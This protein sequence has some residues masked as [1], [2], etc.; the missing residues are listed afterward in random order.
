MKDCQKEEIVFKWIKERVTKKKRE[1]AELQ[2]QMRDAID[3]TN[4]VSKKIFEKFDRRH[5]QTRVE[6]ERRHA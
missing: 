4:E 5:I 2:K 6:F 1:D 3:A